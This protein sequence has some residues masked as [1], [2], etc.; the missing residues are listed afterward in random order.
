MLLDSVA[1]A[2]FLDRD[3]AFHAAADRRIRELA[4]RERLITSV[5]TYAELLTGAARGHHDRGTVRGFFADLIDEVVAVDEP[6]AERAANLRAAKPSLRLPDALILAAAEESGAELVIGGD[7]RW[8]RVPGLRIPVE[9]L[10][11]A[12]S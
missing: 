7:Q 9:L 1:V 11:A 10:S 3:D 5:I 2:G 6:I 8:L 4:G 12:G